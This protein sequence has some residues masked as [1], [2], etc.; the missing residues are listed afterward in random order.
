MRNVLFSNFRGRSR[1]NNFFPTIASM[2]F[3][4]YEKKL[5]YVIERATLRM[6]PFLLRNLSACLQWVGGGLIVG[7][8]SIR[9]MQKNYLRK[10]LPRIKE[11]S[12]L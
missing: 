8:P 6:P 4:I 3:P 7:A 11:Y 1:D 10:D 9:V 5:I 12:C 2:L